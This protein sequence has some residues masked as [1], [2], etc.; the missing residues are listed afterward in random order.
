LA[1]G[2]GDT[3]NPYGSKTKGYVLAAPKNSNGAPDFRQ[4]DY[5]ELSGRPTGA[6]TYVGESTTDP[7]SVSGATIS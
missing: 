1:D 7:T 4:L 6:F 3:K 5:S 2:Y